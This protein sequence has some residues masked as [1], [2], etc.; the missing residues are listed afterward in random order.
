MTRDQAYK[1]IERYMA[2]TS[3]TPIV[4]DVP[5]HT[6]ETMLS[7]HFGV[8]DV[9]IISSSTY[10]AEDGL[11]QWDRL[12]HDLRTRTGKCILA[13]LSDF[14]KLEGAKS[15]HQKYRQLI[16]IMG[17]GKIVVLSVGCRE[18]LDFK[19]PRI[20]DSGK[21]TIMD[22]SEE[23]EKHL[24]FLQPGL[25]EPDLSIK[26]I[27]RLPLQGN[28]SQIVVV[29]NHRSSDFPYSLYAIKDYETHYQILMENHP[30]LN[31]VEEDF[32]STKQWEEL[33]MK[34][35]CCND[36][37]E[38]AMDECGGLNGLSNTFSR[39]E[40]LD[41][42]QK[43]FYLL[44]IKTFG[45][46]GND[47][48]TSAAARSNS[49][50]EFVDHI[51]MD[52]LDVNPDAKSFRQAYDER[53]RL[54]KHLS[55]Y[56]D[57]I[58][59]FCKSIWSKG[60]SA[61]N[62]LTDSSVKEKETVIAF[63]D[64]YGRELGR[65]KTLQLLQAA[66]PA[67]RSY[68]EDFNYGNKFIDKYFRTYKFDKAVNSISDEMNQM[69]ADQAAKRDFN[70]LLQPR[71]LVVD[72]L[73]IEGAV[74]F[75]MD[76][77]GAEYLS[78]LQ[79]KFYENGFDFKCSIARCELPSITSENKDFI[80]VFTDRGC[81]VVS[82]R[83]LDDLKHEGSQSYDYNTTKLPIHI[84]K[85]LQILD[86]LVDHLKTYLGKGKR[87]YIISDHGSSRL[88]VIKESENKWTVSEKGKHSGRCCPRTDIDEK[89]ESATESNGYWCLANYDRFK[90]GRKASVEVHG[91]ALLEE[92]TIPV[93]DI[94]K[95][96]KSVA[97]E[98]KNDGPAL[99]SMKSPAVLKLFVEKESTNVKVTMNGEVYLSIGTPVPYI[100]EIPLTGVKKPD[101]YTFDVYCDDVLVAK[102]LEIEIAN[103]GMRERSFF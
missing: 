74:L 69:V 90:G 98:V 64:K 93:I 96:D 49:I 32:G 38:T 29:T 21:I 19:D 23:D 40:D 51:A 12:V 37:I 76:A 46:K 89:P 25:T 44:C 43:W 62:Y 84:V 81:Q 95:R 50:T 75:F 91:G 70:S 57:A 100:H 88:A 97:V 53:K 33:S 61:V 34:L 103:Q 20:H 42:F 77:L 7:R 85:E 17:I 5:N 80:K 59:K 87:A 10:C 39:F 67:L 8:G 14:L 48:L 86:E 11:P 63:L 68:L 54:L 6:E 52:I 4:V 41:D 102:N 22:G 58:D 16:D 3:T 78:Y 66:Y 55:Q 45:A 101:T 15:M 99:R 79:D 94:I 30:E 47:Y 28:Y 71:S 82:N 1:R 65:K 35:S 13:G 92:L 27:Q 9:T 72:N 26:G 36:S 2:G 83:Q 24:S 18:W 56:P 73:D 60:K 31:H